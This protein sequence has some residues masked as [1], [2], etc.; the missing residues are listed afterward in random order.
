MNRGFPRSIVLVVV[1]ITVGISILLISLNRVDREYALRLIRWG[2]SDVKDYLRFPEQIIQ[3][4]DEPHLLPSDPQPEWFA[5]ISYRV[6]GRLT[7]SSVD[8]LMTR[9]RTQALIIIKDD[10]IVHEKYY[11][12]FNRDSIV[13]SFSS[14]KSFN[15]AMIGIAIDDGLIGSVNDRLVQYLPELTGRGLDDMTLRDLLLM[16]SGIAYK[17]DEN[18]FPLLG[19][20]FSDDA[21]TYYYPDLRQLVLNRVKHGDEEVGRYMHY[22]NYHPILEGMILERVSGMPVAKYLE[23]KIWQPL[24]AEYPASW[25]LD[26]AQTS[27]EKM[28]SGLNGRAID[29]LCRI[30][31]HIGQRLVRIAWER[32]NPKDA[33]AYCSCADCVFS[34]DWQSRQKNGIGQNCTSVFDL[35]DGSFPLSRCGGACRV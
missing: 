15:S 33:W 5:N 32:G 25:S 3:N 19:A 11:N 9:T 18:L 13:T 29:K 16:S 6:N 27:F 7:E 8:E 12:G 34:T 4:P 10:Q 20:P 28:E 26:S 30:V 17:E 35:L 2:E 1:M 24:G 23:Q 14:V 22:N 21:L 31:K